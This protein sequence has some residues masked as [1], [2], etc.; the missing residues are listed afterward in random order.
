[1]KDVKV[2]QYAVV[3]DNLIALCREYDVTPMVP[4]LGI[5]YELDYV[6]PDERTL[7]LVC[8][9]QG[10]GD[11]RFMCDPSLVREIF[12]TMCT[13]LIASNN[14]TLPSELTNQE[15]FGEFAYEEPL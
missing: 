6:V 10:R 12:F 13:R 7:S 11:L 15:A 8:K 3:L 14:G 5:P 1:M 4:V 2:A 9:V